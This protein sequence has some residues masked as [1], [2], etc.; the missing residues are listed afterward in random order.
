MTACS[1]VYLTQKAEIQSQ[2]LPS[3]FTDLKVLLE[4]SDIMLM[5][6]GIY[7][8]VV[9]RSSVNGSFVLHFTAVPPEARKYFFG[10]SIGNE[11]ITPK[12]ELSS[13][14]GLLATRFIPSF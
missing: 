4:P 3:K 13:E 11:R 1:F 6:A 14:S 10:L 9:E 8:K 12:G 5:T 7:G 2:T